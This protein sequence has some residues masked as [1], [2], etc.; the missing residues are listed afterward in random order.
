MNAPVMVEV[1]TET[2]PL[3]IAYKELREKKIPFIIRC[4]VLCW[5]SSAR[6]TRHGT[7]ARPAENCAAPCRA[8]RAEQPLQP[9]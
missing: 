1:G 6:V 2:D 7:A 9:L 4:A 3:E 8:I 5:P